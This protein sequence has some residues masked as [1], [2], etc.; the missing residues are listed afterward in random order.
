MWIRAAYFEG[1][2]LAGRETAFVAFMTDTILPGIRRSPG[3]KRVS[4]WW[5]RKYEDRSDAIFCQL[6]AEFDVEEDIARMIAS[7]ERQ[8]VREQLWWPRRGGQANSCSL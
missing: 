1:A 2:I 8:A 6:I 7:P 4:A 3:V 5:P